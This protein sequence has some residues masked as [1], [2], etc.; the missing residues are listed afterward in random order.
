MRRADLMKT[1]TPKEHIDEAQMVLDD[2]QRP[3]EMRYAGAQTHALLAIAKLMLAQME[4]E[5]EE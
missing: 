2:M 5:G 3:V 4:G 1:Q